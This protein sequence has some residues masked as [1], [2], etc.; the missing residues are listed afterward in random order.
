MLLSPLYICLS[1]INHGSHFYLYILVRRHFRSP[2]LYT[3]FQAAKYD[4]RLSW[5]SSCARFH[6]LLA[7]G[8]ATTTSNTTRNS[9]QQ[10]EEFGVHR[11]QKSNMAAPSKS[12]CLI[13]KHL[14]CFLKHIIL[15]KLNCHLIFVKLAYCSCVHMF[16]K[17]DPTC[18]R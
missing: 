14:F 13:L 16:M 2:L 7:A 5:F 1:L 15:A 18:A 10:V 9:H 3:T 6:F 12:T 17:F 11:H 4:W 8:T